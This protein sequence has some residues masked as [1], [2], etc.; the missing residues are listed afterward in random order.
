MKS[1]PSSSE[2]VLLRPEVRSAKFATCLVSIKQISDDD[3]SRQLPTQL[4]QIEGGTAAYSLG[5]SRDI[6]AISPLS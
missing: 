6:F 2:A 3:D 5:S 4:P 1:I